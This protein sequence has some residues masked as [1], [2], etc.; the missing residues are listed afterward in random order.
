MNLGATGER[1]AAKAL[2][3]KG[4]RILAKN[5]RCPIGEI[6]LIAWD[7]GTIVFVEVKSRA[8]DKHA[9]PEV[10]V[11]RQKQRQVARVARFYIQHKSAHEYPARFD[12]V[13]VLLKQGCKPEVEHFIDA[14]HPTDR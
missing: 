2:K 9:Y 3:R 8:S 6:D 12:V 13:S 7:A 4:Y 11:T 1:I 10:N 14:F 5:Y